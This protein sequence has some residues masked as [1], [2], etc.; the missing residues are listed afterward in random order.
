[1]SKHSRILL[2]GGG[3][4]GPVSPV[5]AVAMEVKKLLPGAE[6]L[7]VG[8]K[9]GPE[10]S[11]VSETGIPFVGIR[12]ARLRRYFSLMNVAD[13]FIFFISLISSFR[14]LK[15]FKPALIFSAGGFVAVPLCWVGRIMGVKVV[16]HQQD[17]RIGLANKLIVPFSQRITTA[18]GQTAKNFHSGPGLLKKEKGYTPEWV[19]NPVRPQIKKPD[20]AQKKFFHLHE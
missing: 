18:F 3:T 19:G 10:K 8:T 20:L 15:K 4:G 12:A 1:M 17:A 2:A 6:F 7:F 9:H 11:L 13:V 16:I 14:I 5:L